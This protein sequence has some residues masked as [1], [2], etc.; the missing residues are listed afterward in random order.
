MIGKFIVNQSI[1]TNNSYYLSGN[2]SRLAYSNK[3]KDDIKSYIFDAVNGVISAKTLTDNLFPEIKP[4]IFISHSS[5]DAKIAIRFANTLYEKY[6]IISFIDSQLWG[7]IDYALKEMHEKYCKSEYSLFYNYDKSNN[8]LSHMHTILSMALM[9]VMDNADSVIFIESDNS[10]Y[11]YMEDN[12]IIPYN[13]I[14]SQLDTLSPWISSEVNFA[15]KLRKKGHIDRDLI[16][17]AGTESYK[18]NKSKEQIVLDSMPKIIHEIDFTDFIE[19]TENSF[20]ESLSLSLTRK[21]PIHYLD[22]IYRKYDQG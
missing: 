5:K 6:G 16:N 7:H 21:Y 15:N 19:I 1:L 8:L 12:E 17:M 14:E 9:R 10:I 22:M 3:S 18:L 4:H 2:N 20:K 11:K 13:K